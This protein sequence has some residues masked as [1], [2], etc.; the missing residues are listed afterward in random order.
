MP[1]YIYI[2]IYP[3]YTCI[4]I[5]RYSWEKAWEVREDG[6]RDLINASGV[7]TALL[8]IKGFS[9]RL[10]LVLAWYRP[11]S[12]V[13]IWHTAVPRNVLRDGF[14]PQFL[15]DETKTQKLSGLPSGSY[16]LVNGHEEIK[17]AHN[18][19]HYVILPS[20]DRVKPTRMFVCTQSSWVIFTLK[21]DK[22]HWSISPWCGGFLWIH[23]LFF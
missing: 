19:N 12:V 20:L 15:D 3:L 22:N 11:D 4:Y 14:H 8:T 23:L 7:S 5:F 21:N 13:G 17:P 9:A 18:Y 16:S 10:W 1:L 6:D 2:Y